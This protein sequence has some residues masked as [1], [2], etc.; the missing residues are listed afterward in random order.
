MMSKSGGKKGSLLHF[1]S[2]SQICGFCCQ[3]LQAANNKKKDFE[4]KEKNNRM[5]IMC[6]EVIS[7]ALI[8]SDTIKPPN[9]LAVYL[10]RRVGLALQ[11]RHTGAQQGCR[12]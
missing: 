11:P 3:Y 4:F 6:V 7:K 12:A 5:Q 2:N 8:A 1:S 9:K 10:R